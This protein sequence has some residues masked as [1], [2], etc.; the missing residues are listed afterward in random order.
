ML[1]KKKSEQEKQDQKMLVVTEQTLDQI[2]PLLSPG[3]QPL[4][5]DSQ[6]IF[7][8]VLFCFVMIDSF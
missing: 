4:H 3:F 5:N 7:Y 8:F 1:P 2:V 6:R